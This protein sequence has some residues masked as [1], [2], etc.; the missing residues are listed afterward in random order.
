MTLKLNILILSFS[1][2]MFS[3]RGTTMETPPIH[4][5]Q[6]MDDFGRL[7]PQS[8]NL[9]SYKLSSEPFED[10]NENSHWDTD[11]PFEATVIQGDREVRHQLH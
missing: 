1:L 10:L 3:C 4:I 11:E 7:D 8:S 5:I 9:A 2:I 6:N